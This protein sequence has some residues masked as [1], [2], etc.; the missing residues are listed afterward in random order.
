MSCDE[1]GRSRNE[2]SFLR[3]NRDDEF[4]LWSGIQKIQEQDL[5]TGLL[6]P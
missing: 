2:N 5:H 6:M 4:S 1:H 3:E